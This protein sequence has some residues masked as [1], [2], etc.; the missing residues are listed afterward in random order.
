MSTTET[1]L[2]K[3]EE[4]KIVAGQEL[5]LLLG[6]LAGSA[7]HLV[8]HDKATCEEA[9][10]LAK[11]KD[12]AIKFVMAAAEPER[13]RLRSA[14]EKLLGERD[15][16]VAALQSTVNR[17]ELE[18]RAW[19]IKERQDAKAEQDKLNKG[20][21]AE[22]RVEVK[23]NLPSVPGKRIVLH[24]RCEV[25]DASKVK[26]DWMVPDVQA[27]ERQARD[28]KDPAKTEKAVGGVRIRI[29]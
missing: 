18:A 7:E 14:L 4:G 12:D 1:A 15:K 29:E 16:I 10:E 23:P 5:H 27:I 3:V 24:Y 11:R 25:L 13:L 26:R 9:L 19:N 17:P 21:R 6:E 2:V 20:Q 22:N 28:D 8:V